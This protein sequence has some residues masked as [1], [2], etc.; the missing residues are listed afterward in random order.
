[1]YLKPFKLTKPS[2][3]LV[4]ILTLLHFSSCTEE[5]E[6]LYNH[7]IYTDDIELSIYE[8]PEKDTVI[9]T[10]NSL[11]TDAE[12][13]PTYTIT[14][15]SLE[16][17]RIVDNQLI[18]DDPSVFDYESISS[19]TGEIE[20][21][22]GTGTY[23]SNFT[24]HLENSIEEDEAFVM[25]WETTKANES[26][27]IYTHADEEK[28]IYYDY[29]VDWGDGTLDQNLTDDRSHTYELPGIYTVTIT[30][31]QFP[32]IT[33]ENTGNAAK[34]KSIEA[35]GT[36]EWKYLTNGF[37]DCANL[38]INATDTPMFT[39]DINLSSLFYGTTNF[40]SDIGNW[41]MSNVNNISNMFRE[42]ISFNQDISGWNTSN[43]QQMHA[44]FLDARSF[45]QSID[46]WDM[47]QVKNTSYMFAN[48]VTFNQDLNSWD[49][50]NVRNMGHMFKKATQFDGNI[51][52]WNTQNVT[53]MTYM[54]N[55]AV[56]FNQDISAW[57]TSNLLNMNHIFTNAQLFNQDISAWDVKRVADMAYAFA[58]VYTFNQDLSNWEVI[59]VTNMRDM[60]HNAHAF[61]QDISS[62]NVANVLNMYRMFHNAYAFNQDL[63]IWDTSKVVNMGET[64]KTATAFDQ[65]LSTWDTSSVG[66]CTN[67]GQGVSSP[68]YVSPVFPEGCSI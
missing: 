58:N 60:F 31:N 47:S 19:I 57:D 61:N 14:S 67:F 3:Y 34:L 28:E 42:A 18:V 23:I 63:S 50:S 15:Q 8:N 17:L 54:F 25:T 16:G 27:I 46:S 24:I 10:L 52:D 33:Q 29:N 7:S 38:V 51:S 39:E 4:S 41:D 12:N 36:N 65:D 62:W 32:G 56:V 44:V 20:A 21:T 68:N 30:G 2:S 13:T 43:I 37:R 22:L 35:W 45:N 26:I 9:A 6:T 40:N 64:F 53:T 1:M 11:D 59:S 48:A 49:V 55:D 66:N 5:V